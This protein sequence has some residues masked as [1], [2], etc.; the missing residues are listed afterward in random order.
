MDATQLL[1][2]RNTGDVGMGLGWVQ[3]GAARTVI[4]EGL[5][6]HESEAIHQ[7]LAELEPHQCDQPG[8]NT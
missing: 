3:L 5:H 4:E 1:D 6:Q 7:K 8:R 2:H